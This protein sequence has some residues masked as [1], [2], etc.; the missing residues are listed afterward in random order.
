MKKILTLLLV[1]SLIFPVWSAGTGKLTVVTD[2]PEAT[3]YIDGKLVGKDAIQAYPVEA[4][5]HYVTVWY[6]GKKAYAQLLNI[7]DGEFKTISSAHFVDLRTS[8]PSRGAVDVEA[9]RLRETRGNMAFGLFGSSPASGLSWKWWFFE[10][11]GVQVVGFLSSSN[12]QVHNQ[13]GGRLLFHLADKVMNETTIT[14]YIAAGGGTAYFKEG[15]NADT[16]YIGE[17]ALGVELGFI[18]LY[19]SLELGAEKRVVT[20]T[21]E[22]EATTDLSNMKVSGGL[23]YYF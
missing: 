16:T 9:A 2:L 11:L 22:E 13:F 10:K 14:A 19:W 7:G 4:G 3:I 6:R 5:E 12:D 18:N 21:N 20:H 17:G 23:H 8:T 1:L 15:G